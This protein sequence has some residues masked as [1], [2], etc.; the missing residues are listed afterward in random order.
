M[1]KFLCLKHSFIKFSGMVAWLK[2]L[3]LHSNTEQGREQTPGAVPDSW[4]KA[5]LYAKKMYE[6]ICIDYLWQNVAM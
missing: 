1:Y 6:V 5:Y 4:Q 2:T 3:L